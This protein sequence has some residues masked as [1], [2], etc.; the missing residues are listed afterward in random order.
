[1]PKKGKKEVPKTGTLFPVDKNGVRSTTH[2]GKQVLAAALRGAGAE[3]AAANVEKLGS[4][5]WRFGYNKA[6]M[7]LVKE[8]CKSPE[9]AL[10]SAKAGLEWM[11]DNFEHAKSEAEPPVKF[12]KMVS[13]AKMIGAQKLEDG[14]DAGSRCM[15]DRCPERDR[16]PAIRTPVGEGGD[17]SSG[18]GTF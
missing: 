12:S 17:L 14:K 2:T 7:S 10:G 1:M 15:S 3:Y 18:H 5:K 11:Y 13:R 4:K 8:S 16:S 6:Y 9:A